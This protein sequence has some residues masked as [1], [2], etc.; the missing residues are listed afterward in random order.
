MGRLLIRAG[1]SEYM[2]GA[3][4]LT[5]H[6]LGRNERGK[7]VLLDAS[8]CE[9]RCVSFNISHQVIVYAICED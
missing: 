7:P 8:D 3:C 9:D 6:H 1:I 2:G 5:R 4:N